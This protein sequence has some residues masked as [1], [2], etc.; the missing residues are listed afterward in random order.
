M[1]FLGIPFGSGIKSI[2]FSAA[3]ATVV[4]GV[5]IM[6][7]FFYEKIKVISWK[8]V[9]VVCLVFSI[10]YFGLA[11]FLKK[12]S[13]QNLSF[14]NEK[15][16]FEVLQGKWK[17]EVDSS[18]KMTLHFISREKITIEVD[19]VE[20]GVSE[21]SMYTGNYTL[22]DKKQIYAVDT[23]NTYELYIN[24]VDNNTLMIENEPNNLLFYK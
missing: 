23:T 12:Q 3:S 13:Q 5:I 24:I 6:F 10:G 4:T 7:S 22:I 8:N 14:E 17:C 19:I 16:Y 20:E 11:F 1:I 18:T 15:S 9:I 2:I 21:H